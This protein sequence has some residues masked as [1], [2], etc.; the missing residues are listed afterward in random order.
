MNQA[1]INERDK[2][3]TCLDRNEASDL[4]LEMNQMLLQ[5]KYFELGKIAYFLSGFHF[6]VQVKNVFIQEI[7]SSIQ[8]F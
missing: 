2:T 1:L 5:A 7:A 8:K 3:Q 4:F 6:Y